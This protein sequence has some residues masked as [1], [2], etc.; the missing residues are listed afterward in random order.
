MGLGFAERRA[1]CLLRPPGS[2]REGAGRDA[3]PELRGKTPRTYSGYG[4]S[5]SLLVWRELGGGLEGTGRGHW[6][7]WQK[8]GKGEEGCGR[9]RGSGVGAGGNDG[10]QRLRGALGEKNWGGRI[11]HL[12]MKL[13][14]CKYN[15]NSMQ[16]SIGFLWVHSS[17]I[18]FLRLRIGANLHPVACPVPCFFIINIFRGTTQGLSCQDWGGL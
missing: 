9:P 11:V 2:G 4:A 15:A 13:I 17:S 3:P 10:G 8:E 18:L 1:C 12:N 16:T 14:T 7:P 5:G 6:A